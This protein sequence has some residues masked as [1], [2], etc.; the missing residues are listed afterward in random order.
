M[1]ILSFVREISCFE[2][3][4]ASLQTVLLLEIVYG[5]EV[6][7]LNL[8]SADAVRALEVLGNTANAASKDMSDDDVDKLIA[9]ATKVASTMKP[10]AER[11]M[12]R[13][14]SEPAGSPTK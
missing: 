3:F 4:L 14:K 10:V 9:E 7:V 5:A 13:A 1:F 11:L 2:F 12:Q 6:K 8:V